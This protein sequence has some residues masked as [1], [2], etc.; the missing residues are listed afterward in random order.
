MNQG[1]VDM[2]ETRVRVLIALV[3]VFAAKVGLAGQVFAG[4]NVAVQ[5]EEGKHID[6][7]AGK[8]LVARYQIG[9][10]RPK[11]IFWPLNAPGGVGITR[12]WPMEEAKPGVSTDHPHQQSAWFCHGDIIPEGI[13][14]KAKVKGIAGVDFWSINKGAGKI[15]HMSSS[16]IAGDASLIGIGNDWVTADGTVVMAE[17]QKIRL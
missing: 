16:T 6:F 8:D 7:L 2:T 12:A 3:L 4:E 5:V 13:E 15:V 17:E 10:D 1:V 9:K 14:L 11:P